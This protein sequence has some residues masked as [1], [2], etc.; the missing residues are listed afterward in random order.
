[1]YD[2]VE[3]S[4]YLPQCRIPRKIDPLV[5]EILGLVICEVKAVDAGVG[6]K[7]TCLAGSNPLRRLLSV[8]A[9]IA[10]WLLCCNSCCA[11]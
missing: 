3:L 1:M 2:A 5:G 10:Q 8:G 9:H 7:K 4:I 11:E 6:G